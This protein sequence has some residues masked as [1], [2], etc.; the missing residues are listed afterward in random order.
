MPR[1]SHRRTSARQVSSPGTAPVGL[2]GKL[3]DTTRVAGRSARSMAS[4]SR[5]QPSSG[6]RATP[7]TSQ[8]DSGTVSAA[9]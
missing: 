1:S 2:C 4:R 8:I 7:V 3:T 6:R 5:A 9:W